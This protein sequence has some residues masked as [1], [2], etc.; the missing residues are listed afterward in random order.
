MSEKRSK[1]PLDD[2]I[3]APKGKGLG[4]ESA[5]DLAREIC[6]RR[7]QA[8]SEKTLAADISKFLSYA[9]PLTA[10]FIE[11]LYEIAGRTSRK[12]LQLAIATHTEEFETRRDPIARITERYTNAERVIFLGLQ[13][14]SANMET[15]SPELLDLLNY[16]IR[17]LIVEAI[18]TTMGVPSKD[19][20]CAIWKNL[21]RRAAEWSEKNPE[22]GTE[23]QLLARLDE[24]LT[25]LVL[26]RL[27]CVHTTLVFD[28]HKENSTSYVWYMPWD[29]RALAKMPAA[30]L[31]AWKQE[32]LTLIEGEGASSSQREVVDRRTALAI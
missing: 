17:Q 32:F 19:L 16:S 3:R 6:N 7:S 27:M 11:Q 12:E 28:P 31:A 14:I 13:P 15:A 26:P 10:A 29:W 4:F 22:D 1:G 18:R 23:E 9:R 8:L 24:R 30:V 5:A 21:S 2:F 25:V 20:A